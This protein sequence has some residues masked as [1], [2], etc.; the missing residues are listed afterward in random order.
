MWNKEAELTKKAVEIAKEK[1]PEGFNKNQLIECSKEVYGGFGVTQSGKLSS[2]RIRT[3]ED[4]DNMGSA[5]ANINGNYPLGMSSCMIVGINGGCG[6]D[7]PVYL[8]GECEVAHQMCE[9]LTG[10]ALELHIR[11]YGD[12]E[13]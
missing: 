3:M 2:K 4:L 5:M 1:H 8:D 13:E 9:G 6:G 11:L 12:D 7:C 10:E